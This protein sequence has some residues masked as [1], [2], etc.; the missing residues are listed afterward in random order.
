ME[1]C[2]NLIIRMTYLKIFVLNLC[3]CVNCSETKKIEILPA[4][5]Q[6]FSSAFI[7]DKDDNI[8]FIV[9]YYFD[10]NCLICLSRITKLCIVLENDFPNAKYY[11]IAS[12]ALFPESAYLIEK[13]NIKSEIL[14]EKVDISLN[15]NFLADINQVYVVDNCNTVLL[16]GDPITDYRFKIKMDKLYSAKSRE[17]KKPL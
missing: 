13:Y 5:N 12:S 4:A 1:N 16:Q 17:L 14:I 6:E 8:N 3:L 11:L 7:N 15:F 2:I 9:F 10:G